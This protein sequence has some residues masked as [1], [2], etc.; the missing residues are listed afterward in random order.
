MAIHGSVQL[1]KRRKSAK[2]GGKI[3]KTY[4]DTI[5]IGECLLCCCYT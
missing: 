1:P 5:V 3:T 2:A 4:A